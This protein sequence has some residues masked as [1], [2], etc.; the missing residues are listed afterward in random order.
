DGDAKNWKA[1]AAA[2]ASSKEITFKNARLEIDKTRTLEQVFNENPYTKAARW[3]TFESGGK[4]YIQVDCGLDVQPVFKELRYNIEMIANPNSIALYPFAVLM[5]S[6]EM[7]F[8]FQISGEKIELVK[9]TDRLLRH[10]VDS[11]IESIGAK[12]LNLGFNYA[13]LA[14]MRKMLPAIIGMIPEN[15][16]ITS[17]EVL[18]FRLKMLYQGKTP[19]T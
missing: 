10:K 18:D 19:F 6:S 11:Q 2:R 3:R 14:E 12:M 16:E 15:R 8:L 7:S 9:I 4:K 1:P 17:K 13:L 5:N